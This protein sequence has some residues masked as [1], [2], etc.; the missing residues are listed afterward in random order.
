[1]EDSSKESPGGAT[2]GGKLAGFAGEG[3][4]G[5]V[6][7]PLQQQMARLAGQQAAIRQAAE[8]LALRLRAWN[9]PGA[10][11]ETAVGHMRE[12]EEA[13]AK[14]YGPGVKQAYTQALETLDAA[15]RTAGGPGALRREQSPL[16]ERL[17]QEITSGLQD[18]IPPG[19]EEMAG[20]YFRE[21]AEEKP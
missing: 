20:A 10:D 18:G 2:G 14:G 7:A 21:L 8:A 13:A 9:M 19:Y 12:L 3:L 17:R 15:R 16:A 4:R 1:V 11:L 5:P 6:P